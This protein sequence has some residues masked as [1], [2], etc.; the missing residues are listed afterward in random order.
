MG[1]KVSTTDVGQNMTM[2]R[3]GA[4]G[5]MQGECKHEG[6]AVFSWVQDSDWPLVE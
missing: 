5:I 3:G 4:I 1:C 2:R 6:S